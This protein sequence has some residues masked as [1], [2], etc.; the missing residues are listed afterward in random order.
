MVQNAFESEKKWCEENR[1]F[2]K[3]NDKDVEKQTTY[4]CT[5][6]ALCLGLKEYIEQNL[7]NDC[8]DIVISRQHKIGWSL[9]YERFQY[10]MQLKYKRNGRH[11]ATIYAV[12]GTEIESNDWC[13]YKS[14]QLTNE[15]GWF[16]GKPYKSLYD[17]L[18]D[19]VD[20]IKRENVYK[21]N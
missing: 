18:K 6:L 20:K 11:F 2:N 13:N 3:W 8:F 17:I 9:G 5:T 21:L 10:E 19:I 15:N 4:L 12:A 14:F 1:F 7:P 16:R